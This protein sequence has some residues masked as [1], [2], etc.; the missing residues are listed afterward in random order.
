[1]T[2][3]Q[4]ALVA[5]VSFPSQLHR[6][7]KREIPLVLHALTVA[8]FFACS[9]LANLAYSYHISIP[10][11]QMFRAGTLP[12]TLLI[13]VLVFKKRFP[14]FKIVSVLAVSVGI[15]FVTLA[16]QKQV[17]A[18]PSLANEIETKEWFI[19]IV[20]LLL[21]TIITALLST[22]QEHSI[23]ICARAP[24]LQSPQTTS[25]PAS[26]VLKSADA[27][28][29][30]TRRRVANEGLFYNHLLALPLFFIRYDEMM[31]AVN[32]ALE[33]QSC[34][35]AATWL[36]SSH[37]WW[38]FLALNAASQVVCIFGVY[39]LQALTSAVTTILVT[40]LRKFLSIVVSVMFFGSAFSLMH[41]I[42]SALVISGSLFYSI[43]PRDIFS[44]LHSTASQS[45]ID[46]KT[47]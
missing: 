17:I 46:K 47:K 4:F 44:R 14:V 5:A 22:L 18:K 41:G 31:T 37:S 40:T 11:H 23:D 43:S 35:H 24:A 38:I 26:F 19:G 28:N 2:M 9:V 6:N 3:L 25:A 1:M 7:F 30:E 15:Y 34:T 16:E 12:A 36:Q 10:V 27:Q 42:G 32:T 45:S 13:N 21:V 33:K 20:I 8:L 29:Q 39:R